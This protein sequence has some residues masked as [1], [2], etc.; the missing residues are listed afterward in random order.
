[1]NSVK[2]IPTDIHQYKFEVDDGDFNPSRLGFDNPDRKKIR[3][4]V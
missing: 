2:L 1:M 3:K 4:A